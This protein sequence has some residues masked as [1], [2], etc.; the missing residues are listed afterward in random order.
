[1][2]ERERESKRELEEGEE[3]SGTHDS[4]SLRSPKGEEGG[5]GGETSEEVRD[6][7]R[8]RDTQV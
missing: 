8:E 7:E 5:G 4:V 1:M 3:R 2:R 6:R